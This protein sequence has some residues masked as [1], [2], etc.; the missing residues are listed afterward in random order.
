VYFRPAQSFA[1]DSLPGTGGVPVPAPAAADVG[2]LVSPEPGGDALAD[3]EQPASNVAL[4]TRAASVN[5][6][7][8]PRVLNMVDLL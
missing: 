3:V 7:T 2:E 4:A 8:N 6:R 5:A 1:A